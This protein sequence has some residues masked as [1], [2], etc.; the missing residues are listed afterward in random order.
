M[1]LFAKFK[2]VLL[3][4]FRATLTFRNFKVALNNSI[5]KKWGSPSSFLSY[6]S[7][8]LKLRV[9]FSRSYC[10]YGNLLCHKINSNLFPDDWT[11]CRYHD[12]AVNKYWVVIMTHQTLSVGNCFQSPSYFLP[13]ALLKVLL[14][15]QGLPCQLQSFSLEFSRVQRERSRQYSL[16]SAEV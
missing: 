15:F 13:I 11:V 6:K 14:S 2:K 4:G 9:L 1:Q 5:I 3:R 8:K 10:C 16:F 12:V 7:L